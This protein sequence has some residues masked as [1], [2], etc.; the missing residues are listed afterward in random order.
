[1]SARATETRRAMQSRQ[2][3]VNE[4]FY[5]VQAEGKNSGRAAAFVRMSGCN[6]KCDFCDTDHE[7]FGFMTKRQIEDGVNRIAPMSSMVVITGGEPTIQLTDEEPMFQGRYVAIETNGI[8]EPPHWVN[9]IT[10]SPK[11]KLGTDKLCRANELK[12]LY[13]QFTEEYLKEVWE[14]TKT[15]TFKIPCYIQPMADKDGKFDVNPCIEFIRK[16]PGWRLSLQWH[17][18]FGVR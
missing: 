8:L 15:L 1:M 6:L 16:N 18:I 9:W 17:K 11:T 5:S 4:I 14:W 13:G 3:K 12:F 7:Q 2:Y 10:V